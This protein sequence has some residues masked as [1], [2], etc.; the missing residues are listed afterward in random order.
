MRQKP[1]VY[2]DSF[3]GDLA[4]ALTLR[5]VYRPP[6][7]VEAPQ[8]TTTV[9]LHSSAEPATATNQQEAQ[10]EARNTEPSAQYGQGVTLANVY[11]YIGE[12]A[13]AKS[14]SAST[15]YPAETSEAN[16]REWAGEALVEDVQ[17]S[18]DPVFIERD[19]DDPEES[20]DEQ[21]QQSSDKPTPSSDDPAPSAAKPSGS[22][23]AYFQPKLMAETWNA[24]IDDR[25]EIQVV[26]EKTGHKPVFK[27]GKGHELPPSSETRE[28]IVVNGIHIPRPTW[29]HLN[30]QGV[31]LTPG[32]QPPFAEYDGTSATKDESLI[33]RLLKPK[34]K[35]TE[36]KRM[37]FTPHEAALIEGLYR[38]RS[39][40][41]MASRLHMNPTAALHT[42]KQLLVKFGVTKT[43]ALLEILTALHRDTRWSVLTTA[44][45]RMALKDK[46]AVVTMPVGTIQSVGPNIPK[47][48][49]DYP[50]NDEGNRLRRAKEQGKGSPAHSTETS[51]PRNPPPL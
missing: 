50:A 41:T 32:T 35:A 51:S 14:A 6:V 8:E 49:P 25:V 3:W 24:K 29:E 28:Y 23:N 46:P 22:G 16:S 38:G 2:A 37:G 21:Q 5:P 44:Q 19:I 12:A 39:I 48:H 4:N 1:G 31:L 36:L 43:D 20:R 15:E 11:R 42:I 30:E 13:Q 33:H 7:A 34:I 47:N 45:L 9:T 10:G 26:G 17:P 40:Y 27:R 18:N